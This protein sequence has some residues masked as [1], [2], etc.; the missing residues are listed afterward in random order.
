V[1]GLLQ[2]GREVPAPFGKRSKNQK[3][4][5]EKFRSRK[6]KGFDYARPINGVVCAGERGVFLKEKGGSG[7]P[8]AYGDP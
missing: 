7:K 1:K 5:V 2:V 4:P 8:G 6:K 3:R